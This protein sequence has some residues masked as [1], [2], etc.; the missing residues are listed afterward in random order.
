MTEREPAD[1]PM[2]VLVKGLAAAVADYNSTGNALVHIGGYLG[3][4]AVFRCGD[5]IVKCFFHSADSKFARECRAYDFLAGSG[6]PVPVLIASGRLDA[7]PPWILTTGLPGQLGATLWKDLKTGARIDLNR[8]VG[9]LLAKLHLLP[10][11][12]RLT[13]LPLADAMPK[14]FELLALRLERYAHEAAVIDDRAASRAQARAWTV[15]LLRY[16]PRQLC[17]T[18]GDFS[19]RNLNFREIDGA[20]KISGLF[21]FEHCEYGDPAADFAKMLI[22]TEDWNSEEFRSF[23]DAYADLAPLPARERVLLHLGAFALDAAGWAYDKDRAFYT[24]LMDIVDRIAAEPEALPSR[25]P[26]AENPASGPDAY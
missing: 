1:L 19:M 3:R 12:D 4:S 24:F 5:L 22:A 15:D 16:R 7:G 21:D 8:Q 20:W 18:H 17:F 23:L 26:P 6:L 2:D 10:V 9:T 25:L 14:Y 11:D 13:G